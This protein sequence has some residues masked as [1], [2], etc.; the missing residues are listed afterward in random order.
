MLK[1][2]FGGILNHC[3]FV[4][5]LATR[6]MLIRLVVETFWVVEFR[7]KEPQPKVKEGILVL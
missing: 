1:I 6:L 2:N 5:L 3:I 4:L 7:P